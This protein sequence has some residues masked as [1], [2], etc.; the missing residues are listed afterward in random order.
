M[1]ICENGGIVIIHIGGVVVHGI[2]SKKHHLTVLIKCDVHIP[3]IT[4]P[5]PAPWGGGVL[6]ILCIAHG[7]GVEQEGVVVD[8]GLIINQGVIEWVIAPP[9]DIC[10]VDK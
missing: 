5:L 8:E 10:G 7:G 3:L 9:T 6:I 2:M 4:H 1:V